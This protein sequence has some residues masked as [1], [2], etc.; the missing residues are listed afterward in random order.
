[1]KTRDFILVLIVVAVVAVLFLRTDTTDAP[2]IQPTTVARETESA[3]SPSPK[4]KETVQNELPADAS[5]QAGE[6]SDGEIPDPPEVTTELIAKGGE[7]YQVNCAFCHGVEMAGDGDAGKVLDPAPTDLRTSAHYKYG[8]DPRSI[9]RATAHGIEGTGMAP[10]GDILEPYDMWA[11]SLYVE[12]RIDQ[13]ESQP[14]S[15]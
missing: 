4:P 1:M 5:V 9:Y 11:I 15:E 3:P 6:I 13:Q 14:S 12:S 8:T 7:L 10:W 2:D